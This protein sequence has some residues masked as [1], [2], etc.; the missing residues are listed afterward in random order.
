MI[1]NTTA[2]IGYGYGSFSRD[3]RID[4][5]KEKQFPAPTTVALCFIVVRIRWFVKY[6][7]LIIL[8]VNRKITLIIFYHRNGT[9]EMGEK[10]RKTSWNQNL[11]D[12]MGEQRERN[13]YWFNILLK[14]NFSKLVLKLK[15]ALD[16]YAL[17]GSIEWTRSFLLS[18]VWTWC[19][20][21]NEIKP[22][23]KGSIF[24]NIDQ[25]NKFLTTI[26]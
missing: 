15:T 19:L 25:F 10:H 23:F 18:T 21:Y 22:P 2:V 8:H 12:I 6:E 26:S 14:F 16:C 1:L 17:S 24:S 7:F 13:C 4:T 11:S 9:K 3:Y 5:V 20:N